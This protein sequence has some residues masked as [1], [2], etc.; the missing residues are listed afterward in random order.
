MVIFALLPYH[1]RTYS[2]VHAIVAGVQEGVRPEQVQEYLKPR[3]K[4]LGNV[5][6]TFGK[7]NAASK[8]IIESGSVTLPDGVVIR[9]ETADKEVVFA[10]SSKLDIDEIQALILI[11]SFLYDQGLP[12]GVESTSG[13]ADEI[14]EAFH[15]F[16]LSERLHTYRVLIPLF[17]AREDSE[18]PFYQVAQTMLPQ[19]IPD[20]PKFAESL[21]SE[22]VRKTEVKLPEKY[23]H[24]P[25]SATIWAKQN[26]KEQ[27]VLL[28]VL[29]WTMWGF[30]PCTGK[31]V[32]QILEASYKAVLGSVQENITLLLDDE[33][34][35]LQQD[36]A[37]IWILINVEILELETVG[38]PGAINFS[39]SGD[40]YY[41]SPETLKRL[42]DL[43][44]SHTDSQYSATYLSWAYVLYNFSAAAAQ[45]SE[46]PPSFQ[47]VLD[48]INQPAGR[49]YP[50]D[51]ELIHT[52]MAK[53]SLD[54]EV[55]V[56]SLLLNLLTKSSLF[57]TS[58]AWKSGSSIT[59]PNA[60]AYRSVVKGGY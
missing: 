4:Q 57:V 56:L 39:E 53:A 50:K 32:L 27:L 37:A 52:Q 13:M 7:P 51:R 47:S 31:L 54:A 36:C 3:I 12:S 26:L 20:G 43:I 8:K 48:H 42:H 44:T 28:E 45:T 17:R 23:T 33:S 10:I 19:I 60:I 38:E 25:K 18:D 24:D 40:A 5:V 59:D 11:R 58:A 9:V 46:I 21:I 15:P 29:F 34:L 2:Q 14:Y 16:Y 30:V 41:S 55:G 22:Y 1:F 35:H 6:D 49:S